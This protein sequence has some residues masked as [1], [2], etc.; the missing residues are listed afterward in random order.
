MNPILYKATLC[1][2][3]VSLALFTC[4]SGSEVV[5]AE[6]LRGHIAAVGEKTIVVATSQEQRPVTI[7]DNTKVT[8]DG[9][10]AKLTQL[11]VGSKVVVILEGEGKDAKAVSID[12]MTLKHERSQ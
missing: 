1:V 6:A 2:L 9:Q 7:T 10:A 4:S 12:A 8:L 3:Q 11:P 5:K